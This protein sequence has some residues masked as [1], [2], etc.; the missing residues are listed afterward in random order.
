VVHPATDF[1]F[2]PPLKAVRAGWNGFGCQK[3][4]RASIEKSAR[5]GPLNT[6]RG[7]RVASTTSSRRQRSSYRDDGPVIRGFMKGQ[8]WTE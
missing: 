6:R 8:K 4:Y 7:H 1:F 2:P 3:E 5:R